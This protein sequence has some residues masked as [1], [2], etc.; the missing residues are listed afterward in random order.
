[1]K[2]FFLSSFTILLAGFSLSSAA[3]AR[4]VDLNNSLADLNGD[5]ITTLTELEQFNRDERHKN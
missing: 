2:R 1:M 3:Y 4:Q 5:G